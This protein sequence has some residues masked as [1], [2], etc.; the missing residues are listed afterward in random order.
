MVLHD[1]LVFE[2]LSGFDFLLQ[3][4]DCF[5]IVSWIGQVKDLECVFVVVGVGSELDFGAEA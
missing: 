1:V 3:K 5:L 2:L 4:I